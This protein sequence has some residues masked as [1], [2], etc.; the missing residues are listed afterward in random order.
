MDI[1]TIKVGRL[2]TNCYVL[3][4]KDTCL[5][6]DPGADYNNIISALGNNALLGV[7]ITHDHFDHIG[8]LEQ[9]I[10]KYKVPVYNYHCLEEKNYK[11]NDFNFNV[12]YTPGHTNDSITLYFKDDSVMFTGDFLFKETIGRTDLPTGSYSTMLDSLL[13]IKGYDMNIKVYPGHGDSSTLEWE[14]QYNLYLTNGI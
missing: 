7:V 3:T 1:K 5:V 13:K 12:I 8:A 14:F 2:Q 9:I 10:E 11:I 4:I 6:I